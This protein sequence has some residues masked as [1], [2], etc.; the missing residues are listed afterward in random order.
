VQVN[1]DRRLPSTIHVGLPDQAISCGY[2]MDR[3]MIPSTV[4]AMTDNIDDSLA[5]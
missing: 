2:E 4:V 5:I 1:P 3:V